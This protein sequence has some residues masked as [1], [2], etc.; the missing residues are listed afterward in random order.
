[1]MTRIG[2]RVLRLSLGERRVLCIDWDERTLRVLDVSLSRSDVRIRRA[3]NVPVT[4][5]TNV[6][7]PASMGDFIRRALAEHRIR[8]RKTIVD[9]PRQDAVMNLISL[10][11]GSVDEMASMVHIQVAKYLP[12]GKDEGV[13]DFALSSREKTETCEVWVAT[14][15]NNI[16]D[17]YQQVIQAAGL[18]LEKVGL[19][20]YANQTAIASEAPVSGRMVFVDVG[21]SITEIN[22]I[23]DGR[24]VY[25]RAASV[26]VPE[27]GLLETED[28]EAPILTITSTEDGGIPLADDHLP[29]PGA[30]ETLMVEVNRTIQAYRSTDPGAE[31]ER[32]LLAG[33][34]G[35]NEEV[36]EAFENR[37]RVPANIYEV[38]SSLH[39]P[40]SKDKSMAYSS[41]IGLALG[42]TAEGMRHI[43]FLHPKEPEAQR[44]ERVKQM[45]KIAVVVALFVAAAGIVAYNP[46]REKNATVKQLEAEIKL[47]KEGQKERKELKAQLEDARAWQKRNLPWIDVLKQL[48]QV[49]P[50]NKE[51][52]I[53]RLECQEKNGDIKFEILAAN[54]KAGSSFIEAVK[55]IKEEKFDGKTGDMGINKKNPKYRYKDEIYLKL[56]RLVTESTR[57]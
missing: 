43:D 8:T 33:T 31:I 21:P 16:L 28:D 10:P 9:I 17:Y 47:L 29:S 19:R 5:G 32:I 7:D 37:F 2:G 42:T 39:W 48:A 38:P 41:V 24:L 4:P 54:D 45:P 57:K 49:F 12:F 14:V 18:K 1:M 35:I 30:M 46:I 25:S 3:A 6:R 34:V 52:Y 44:R 36:A 51:A 27:D 26:S 20:P 40:K 56:E 11:A 50:S 53:T 55:K 22:I 23:R 13:I 15:R